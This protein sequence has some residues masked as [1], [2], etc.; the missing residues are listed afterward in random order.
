MSNENNENTI[1]Q[2]RIKS[3]GIALLKRLGL[4]SVILFWATLVIFFIVLFSPGSASDFMGFK[5]EAHESKIISNLKWLLKWIRDVVTKLDFGESLIPP[6]EP[7]LELLKPRLVKTAILT[8]LSLLMTLIIG[9]IIGAIA[10]TGR[11]PRFSIAA[12]FLSYLASAAPI[13]WVAFFAIYLWFPIQ[14]GPDQKYPSWMYFILPI[15]LLSI[16]NGTLGE[17][18]RHIRGE[19]EEILKK[20]YMQAVRARG[21]GRLKYWWHA[22]RNVL[23]PSIGLV[24]SNLTLLLGGAVVLEYVFILRG[25]G[26]QAWESAG[27]RDTPVILGITVILV[28]CVVVIRFLSDLFCYIIDPRFQS[29]T[30]K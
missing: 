4:S 27:K 26:Y 13:Y 6:Y 29:E 20:E 25:I 3:L 2:E 14:G 24:T 17:I 9:L 28:F 15:F 16:F 10:A 7:V 1:A 11:Y 19:L 21:L 8:L 18:I 5:S 22:L 12:S 30:E 23:A